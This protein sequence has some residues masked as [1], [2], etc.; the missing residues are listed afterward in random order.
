MPSGRILSWSIWAPLAFVVLPAMG[1]LVVLP[2]TAPHACAPYQV[3]EEVVCIASEGVQYYWD[4]VITYFVIDPLICMVFVEPP[5]NWAE[6][7]VP[8]FTGGGGYPIWFT[9]H[10]WP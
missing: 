3:D 1:N 4:G 10:P 7:C 5:I 6:V 8:H 9:S 2:A